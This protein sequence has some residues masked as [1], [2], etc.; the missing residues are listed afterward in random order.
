MHN[1]N[2]KNIYRNNIGY[3]LNKKICLM[4]LIAKC[5]VNNSIFYII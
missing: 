2:Y 4:F 5:I 1:L 3:T